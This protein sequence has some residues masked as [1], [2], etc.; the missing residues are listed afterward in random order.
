L[1]TFWQLED[2]W[3]AAAGGS[4]ARFRQAYAVWGPRLA[5]HLANP[6]AAD[7]AFI[8]LKPVEIVARLLV[9]LLP[10]A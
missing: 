9:A 10:T 3:A 2:L 6:W 1:Q 5:R 8:L 7:T 4:H